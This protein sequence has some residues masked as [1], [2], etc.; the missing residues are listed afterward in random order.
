MLNA[1]YLQLFVYEGLSVYFF[2][3]YFKFSGFAP[4]LFSFSFG[5]SSF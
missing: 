2:V 3:A 1:E 4:T 5:T